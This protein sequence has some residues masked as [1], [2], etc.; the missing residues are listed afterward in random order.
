MKLPSATTAITGVVITLAAVFVYN[1]FIAEP[2]KTIA[3]LGEPAK[4]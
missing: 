4:K 3:N 2:G 1:R